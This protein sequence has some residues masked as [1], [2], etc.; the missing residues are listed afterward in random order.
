MK[1]SPGG[2][3]WSRPGGTKGNNLARSRSA[4]SGRPW[5]ESYEGREE[6][7]KDRQGVDK[8]LATDDVKGKISV[9]KWRYRQKVQPPLSLGPPLRALLFCIVWGVM[10][11]RE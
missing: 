11:P 3:F 9:F 5:H 2:T 10:A 8:A 6:Q 4:W 1:Q 7:D